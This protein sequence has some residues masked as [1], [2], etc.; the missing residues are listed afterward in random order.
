MDGIVKALHWDE[1]VANSTNTLEEEEN[2]NN[3]TTFLD[4]I[5]DINK[6]NNDTLTFDIE[7]LP[8]RRTTRMIDYSLLGIS[9]EFTYVLPFLNIGFPNGPSFRHGKFFTS[10]N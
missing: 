10:K 7:I 2:S 3:N 4:D 6:E 1:I 5:E 9:I 8:V